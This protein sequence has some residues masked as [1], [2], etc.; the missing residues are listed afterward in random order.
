[1][2]INPITRN[3]SGPIENLII[4][5]HILKVAEQSLSLSECQS[6]SQNAT[7][8]IEEMSPFCPLAG[9]IHATITAECLPL[10]ILS[11]DSI[12]W[13]VSQPPKPLLNRGIIKDRT[14]DG[15]PGST[16]L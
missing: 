10:L 7:G 6:L 2:I 9:T 3:N 1:M 11:K 12:L 8:M 4:F 14:P 5:T 15:V 16:M 13:L